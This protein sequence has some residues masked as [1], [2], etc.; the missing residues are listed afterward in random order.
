M[1]EFGLRLAISL[2]QIAAVMG[3]VVIT[4][5]ILT[6]AE[7]KVLGWMQ[8]RMGPMEV[9]P[10]GILQPFADAITGAEREP[11]E[12]RNTSHSFDL[13]GETRARPNARGFRKMVP[14]QSARP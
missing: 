9:G 4:V 2:T 12:R 7:R 11:A 14:G 8:D 10:Y 3:I 13:P 1:T 5:L 6:L